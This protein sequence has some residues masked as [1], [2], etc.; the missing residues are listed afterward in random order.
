VPSEVD[1]QDTQKTIFDLAKHPHGVEKEGTTTTTTNKQRRRKTIKGKY[2][3]YI[4]QTLTLQLEIDNF[5]EGN[6]K[7]FGCNWEKIT[8]D[9]FILNTPKCRLQLE[10]ENGIIPK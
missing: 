5:K 4:D 7:N 6:I 8:S 3:L 9:K 10:F 2:K 1:I